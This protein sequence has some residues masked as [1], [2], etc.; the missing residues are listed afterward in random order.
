MIEKTSG[1][2]LTYEDLQNIHKQH[3][4]DGLVAILAKPPSCS[5]SKKPRVTRTDRILTSIVEHFQANTNKS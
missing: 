2:G 3:G 4:D 1:T 5:T